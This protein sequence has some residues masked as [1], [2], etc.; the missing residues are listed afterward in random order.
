MSLSQPVF[1]RIHAAHRSNG[2]GFLSGGLCH[3]GDHSSIF[4]PSPPRFG[5]GYTLCNGRKRHER[6]PNHDQFVVRTDADS[7]G[8][9]N[10]ILDPDVAK[11]LAV[12]DKTAEK[13]KNSVELAP[14]TD[15]REV[16][17]FE[18]TPR[19]VLDRWPHV[20]TTRAEAQFNGLRVP[21]VTGTR[22]HDVAGSLTYYFDKHQQLQRISLSGMVGDDRHLVSVVTQSFALK[23]ESAVGSGLYLAKWNGIPTSALWVRRLSFG[24]AQGG[25]HKFKFSLELN[26]GKNYFGLSS[27]FRQLLDQSQAMNTSATSVR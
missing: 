15:L 24:Q 14:L 17:Q 6:N 12:S 3:V 9:E 8:A 21:L 10:G 2:M 22:A 23:P 25:H 20:S 11:I 5:S 26:R 27:G 7:E 19:W 1:N 18:I 16:L 13:S 4:S